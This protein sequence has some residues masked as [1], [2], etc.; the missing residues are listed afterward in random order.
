LELA[1]AV[2]ALLSPYLAR[3]GG[4]LAERAGQGVAVAVSDLYRLV[5]RRFDDDPDAAARRALRD[6]EDQPGDEERQ[7]A[8]VDVLAAKVAAHSEFATELAEL[9]RGV[10]DGR[11][12]GHFL[13]QVY[14]GEVGKIV[15][16]NEADHIVIN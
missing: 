2:V 3:A 4:A 5:R 14:G 10:T 6:L 7:A 13:T 1:A 9:V 11:P 8:L 12:V 15:N 16:I